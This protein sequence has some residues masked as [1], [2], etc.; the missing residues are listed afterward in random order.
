MAPLKSSLARSATKLLNVFRDGDL[1]LRGKSAKSRFIPGTVAA[2]GGTEYTPG[3]GYKYHVFTSNQNI[4]VTDVGPGFVDFLLVGGGGGGGPNSGSNLG[5]GGGG[6]GGF[7]ET[8]ASISVATYPIVIGNGGAVTT[9][10]NPSTAFGKTAYG[11]G[12]GVASSPGTAG[13][14]GGGGAYGGTG[15]DGLNPATPAPVVSS[16]FPAESHPYAFVQGYPG[17]PGSSS[18]G[19]ECPGAGGGGASAAGQEA[20]PMIGGVTASRGGDGRAAWSGDTGIPGSYGTPGPS[21]GRWFAGGGGG[22]IPAPG[23]L[24]APSGGGGAGG[25]GKGSG[26]T[27]S[28]AGTANTGGGGGAGAYNSTTTAGKAGGSGICIV[29]YAV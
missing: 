15:G 8:T 25:G 22:G 11:G 1:S 28:E 29:R 5:G 24:P 17:G 16:S 3:N 23:G 12:K 21:A 26:P 6:A 20:H 14:S 4:Q 10:G 18:P 27:A 13:G 9:E 19:S 2:S 7:L